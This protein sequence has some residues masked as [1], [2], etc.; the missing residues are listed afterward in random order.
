[1][2]VPH[3]AVLHH[4]NDL[5]DLRAGVVDAFK[6]RACREVAHLASGKALH[7]VTPWLWIATKCTVFQRGRHSIA[8][9]RCPTWRPR[10]GG[11]WTF[12]RRVRF[13]NRSNFW[14]YRRYSRSMTTVFCIRVETTTPS[15]IWPRTGRPAWN[16]HFASVQTFAGEGTSMPMS[17]APGADGTAAA[18]AFRLAFFSAID[19]TVHSSRGLAAGMGCPPRRSRRRHGRRSGT[20]CLPWVLVTCRMGHLGRAFSACHHCNLLGSYSY[21]VYWLRVRSCRDR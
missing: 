14:M 15:S 10:H 21:M 3:A 18:T 13:S 11:A 16:G 6:A 1:E 20:G 2:P 17:R 4:L 5:D 12:N 8:T 9:R 19:V 7:A